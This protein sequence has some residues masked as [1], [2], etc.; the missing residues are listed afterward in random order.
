MVESAS[1]WAAVHSTW[2]IIREAMAAI[3][4]QDILP[5]STTGTLRGVARRTPKRFASAGLLALGTLALTLLLLGNETRAW[6]GHGQNGAQPRL[7]THA[8]TQVP[9]AGYTSPYTNCRFGVGQAHQ[10]LISYDVASLNVGWYVDWKTQLSP[11]R[12][13]GVEYVQMLRMVG[14]TSYSPSGSALADRIAANPGALWLVGNE[15]DCIYQDNVLPQNYAQAYH[16]AYFF[17]KSHDPTARVA[18]GGIVQPTPLRMQ[19]LDIVLSSY[20]SLYNEPLPTDAWHIHTFILREA[21]CD[22]YPGECWGSEIPPGISADHGMMYDL[23]DTDNLNIF[24]ERIVQFRQW[25]RDRG[26]QNTPLIITEYGTL[27][28][29]SY[30]GWDEERGKVF[31]YGTF[32]FL[33]TANDPGLGY[34]ADENRLVQRW[35]WYSLDDTAYGGTLFDPSTLDLLPMGAYFGAYT[36]AISP[37]VDLLAVDVGQATPI[38]LAPAG[39][40]T[41]TLQA[42]VSNV[43]NVPTAG[44]VTVRFLDGEGQQIGSDQAISTAVAGCATVEEITLVWPDVAP[45]SHVVQVV[46]D[47]EDVVSEGNEGNNEIS[48]VVFVAKTH[49]FLP[50]ITRGQ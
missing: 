14:P 39:A 43:G 16:H 25:M 29:H 28:P 45:G 13:G 1:W 26:Y 44:S 31:M 38:P 48:G 5:S 6:E 12:P 41:I 4:W 21:D 2:T 32:D 11:S 10:P 27:V 36:G 30:Q 33:L 42:R 37:T 40:A 49:A 34:P 24:Q 20:V 50:L 22:V 17:I 7:T 23:E 15:P 8:V 19:Y 3:K 46:V 9:S 35:L 47:P 18:V